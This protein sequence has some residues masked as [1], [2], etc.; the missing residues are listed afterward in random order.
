MSDY[1][2]LT[3]AVL[4]ELDRTL[5][6][7]DVAQVA[8]LNAAILNAPRIFVAGKG[9][10]GL[11]MSAFAMRLMHLGRHVHVVGEVTTPGIKAGELLVIGSG[12]GRTD[13]LVQWAEKAKSV[14]ATVALITIMPVSRVGQH[15]DV[16]VRIPAVS[17]KINNGQ[18]ATSIQPMGNLFEQALGILLDIMVMQLMDTLDMDS[19]TM[20][21]RHANME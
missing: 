17:P 1:Q 16:I 20:F 11:R 3:A 4:A 19:D 21:T 5:K 8:A 2:A 10:T 18:A 6:A 12:S 7:I 9:R 13:S 15:A 14:G